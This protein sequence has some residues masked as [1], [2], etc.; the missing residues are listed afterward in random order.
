[1]GIVTYDYYGTK[2]Q[3]FYASGGRTHFGEG[4][5]RV[6]IYSTSYDKGGPFNEFTLGKSMAGLHVGSGAAA[7]TWNLALGKG[8]WLHDNDDDV[9]EFWKNNKG[10]KM[11]ALGSGSYDVIVPGTLNVVGNLYQNGSQI[12]PG[13]GGGGGAPTDASYVTLGTDGDLS[14]ERVLTAGSDIDLADGGAGSTV[15]I[16]L[17]SELNT[18]TGIYNTSLKVGRDAHNLIDY[19]TDD[20]INFR[21]GNA[22]QMKITDG[23]LEPETDNDITLGTSTKGFS[24]VRVSDGAAYYVGASGGVTQDVQVVNGVVPLMGPGGTVVG[25]EVT[26][27]TLEIKGGIITRVY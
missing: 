6:G 21:A 9:T 20:E 17:E 4:R 19:G 15:T 10:T 25:I 11:L 13:G 3:P 23:T 24:Q 27:V 12:T 26:Q 5:G 2:T 1:M 14:A 8:L 18:P 22:D 7:Q 16:N